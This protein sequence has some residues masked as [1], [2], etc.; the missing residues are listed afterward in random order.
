MPKIRDFEVERKKAKAL[1]ELA[2]GTEFPSEASNAALQ[3]VKLIRDHKL[4]D[5]IIKTR[6]VERV[7]LESAVAD[8]EEPEGWHQTTLEIGVECSKCHLP[9]EIGETIW[10]LGRTETMVCNYCF[11]NRGRWR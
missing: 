5:P 9:F 6:V 3:A 8:P 2:C 7:I 11:S 1:V 10:Q 4:L